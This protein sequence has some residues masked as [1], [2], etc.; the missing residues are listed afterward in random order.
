MITSKVE[1]KELVSRYK[2]LC[3]TLLNK[4][5]ILTFDKHIIEDVIILDIVL[6]KTTGLSNKPDKVETEDGK[7][8]TPLVFN[9]ITDSGTLIFLLD[10][11]TVTP[12]VNGIRFSVAQDIHQQSQ[13]IDVDMRLQ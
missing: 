8:R 6:G 7:N 11:T 10:Y 5:C 12:I 2:A 3:M 1:A 9:V 13:R 4:P